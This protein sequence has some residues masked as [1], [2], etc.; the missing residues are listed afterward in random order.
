MGSVR[1]ARRRVSHSPSA[2]SFAGTVARRNVRAVQV[3]YWLADLVVAG[4]HVPCTRGRPSVLD[5]VRGHPAEL[6]LGGA[7][8][9]GVLMRHW[10]LSG[11]WP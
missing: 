1:R 2:F 4:V 5:K 9:H 3:S 8:F 6:W 7:W 10:R 11:Q